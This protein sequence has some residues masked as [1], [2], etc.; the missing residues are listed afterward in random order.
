MLVAALPFGSEMGIGVNAELLASSKITVPI[1]AEWVIGPE[2]DINSI[3][4]E[5]SEDG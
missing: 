3:E 5:E 4:I 1:M 2:L